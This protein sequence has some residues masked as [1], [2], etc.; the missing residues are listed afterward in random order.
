MPQSA[1]HGVGRLRKQ[2]CLKV[3]W[4]IVRSPVLPQNNPKMLL[5]VL[6]GQKLTWEQRD[7]DHTLPGLAEVGDLWKYG[8]WGILSKLLSYTLGLKPYVHIE[9]PCHDSYMILY[10]SYLYSVTRYE[11]CIHWW[12]GSMDKGD[13]CQ[14]RWLEF[15]LGTLLVEGENWLPQAVI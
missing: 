3:V 12:D 13:C 8:H 4:A 10:Y 2:C 5:W 1:R 7:L 9:H 11:W 14:A 15:E 6:R